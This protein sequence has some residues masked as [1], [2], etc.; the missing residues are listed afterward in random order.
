MRTRSS[1]VALATLLLASI[2]SPAL[3][4]W[5]TLGRA[6]DTAPGDHLGPVIAGD[7]A[8]GSSVSLSYRRLFPVNIRVQ[9]VLANGIVDV[10]WPL[11]GRALLTDSLGRAIIPRGL[12]SPAIVSDGAGG[13]IV[14][15]PDDRGSLTGVDVYAQHVLAT[16]AIDP[17]WPVNGATLCSV[18]G[19]QSGPTILADGAGGAFVAWTDERSG[20]TVNDIDVFAQHVLASGVVDPSWPA[21]GAPVSTAPK[22]QTQPHLVEDGDGGFFVTFIDFQTGNPGSDIFAQ[23]VLRSG[24]ADPAWPVNGRDLS[25]ALGSQT[26]PQ[27]ASDGAHG[28][29][30]A[31][32]DMRAG[33]N[34]IY[35]QRVLISGAIAPGWPVAGQPIATGPASEVTPAL[36]ADGAGGAILA[37]GDNRSGHH[38]MRAAHV[39]GTAALDPAWPTDG[40]PLSAADCEESNQIVVSDGAGGAVVAWQRCFDI[41]AQH[42][43]ASGRL[44]AA[45]PASGRAVVAIPVSEQH[46]P[47][48]VAT[49]G[50]GA[51]VTWED[52]RDGLNDIYAL[53]VLEAGTLD[54]PGP[55]A[56]RGLAFARPS[57]NPTRGPVQLHF[58]LPQHSTAS[59]AI[60]DASGRRIRLLVSGTLAPGDH[61]VSW[62]LLDEAGHT[63][64]NGLYFARLATDG[65]EQTQKIL[66]LR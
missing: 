12:E 29:M 59:L 33:N 32:I 27:I 21:N 64:G 18:I 38:N 31:W 61:S 63:V 6:I 65:G 13:A 11:N 23:H 14:T 17:S 24:V 41:F 53:Q 60:F 51:I 19:E 34:D 36:V 55:D 22:A 62:D 8:G 44:D 50:S 9:H 10:A 66:T 42:V 49:G 58:S 43:L 56:S 37:W 45:Y 25:P 40:V 46:E 57:P 2:V 16:G 35:A 20:S 30:V 4:E 28:A 5:P 3:A 47:D 7:G 54:V 39:L 52:T 15:W 48:M 26:A 1:I